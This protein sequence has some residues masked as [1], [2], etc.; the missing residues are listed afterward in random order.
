MAS[1]AFNVTWQI[2]CTSP[3]V[4]A[5]NVLLEMVALGKGLE[6]LAQKRVVVVHRNSTIGTAVSNGVL[7]DRQQ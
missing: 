7:A 6:L 5:N 3:D 1:M 2:Q 4:L